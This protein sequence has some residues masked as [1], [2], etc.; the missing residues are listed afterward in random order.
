MVTRCFIAVGVLIATIG[1]AAAAPPPAPLVALGVAIERGAYPRTTSVLLV[2]DGT[3]S[4]ERYFGPGRPELLNNTRSATKILAALAVGAAIAD[5]AIPSAR[6]P[7]FAFFGDLKPFGNATP[8]KASITIEDLLTM[9]SALACDDADEQSP[10]NE[11]RMHE[12]T[13]W[14]RWVVNLPTL[15]GCARDDA[16]LG[17]WHYCTANAFLAGQIVQR[18]TRTP[19]DA[20]V[21]NRLLRPLGVRRWR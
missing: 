1:T 21:E 10:G 14:T 9:S 8:E 19:V 17:P 6:A 20:Y 13:N 12:Q 16:G 11:D 4:Y 18:A 7:A 15:P 2:Q 5:G 3:I